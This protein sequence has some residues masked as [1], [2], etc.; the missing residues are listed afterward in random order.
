MGLRTEKGN[1]SSESRGSRSGHFLNQISKITN[2]TSHNSLSM[3][4]LGKKRLTWSEMIEMS[5]PEPVFDRI[6]KPKKKQVFK[7][8]NLL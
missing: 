7:D 5:K 3:F 1:V 4:T 8:P 6:S 2:K